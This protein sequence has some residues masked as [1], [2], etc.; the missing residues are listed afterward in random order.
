MVKYKTVNPDNFPF[1]SRDISWIA[2]PCLLLG[3][4]K[5]KTSTAHHSKRIILHFT[6]AQ[7]CALTCS[8]FSPHFDFVQDLLIAQKSDINS[9]PS[10]FKLYFLS[11][12][13]IATRTSK[14]Q[15]CNFLF[16]FRKTK[17]MTFSATR[18]SK[19]SW[20]ADPLLESHNLNN[21]SLISQTI[22]TRKIIISSYI[23]YCALL[24]L[25]LLLTTEDVP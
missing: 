14:N 11:Y 19:Q 18:I 21:L 12:C 6:F 7:K 16:L 2:L 20:S 23:F 24:L 9:S 4:G 17:K 22:S 10:H 25:S 5:I 1:L 8:I 15:F 3:D 13:F